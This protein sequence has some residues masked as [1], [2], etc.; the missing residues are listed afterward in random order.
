MH[1]DS[2]HNPLSEAIEASRSGN[3]PALRNWL[4]QGNNP[5]V[6]DD[7]GWTPLL[8]AAARGHHEA[9][10]LLLDNEY[11]KAD[12]AFPHRESAALAIHMAGH[13]GNVRTAEVILDHRPDHLNAVW[14]LN[15]HTVLLQAVFYGHLDMAKVLLQRGADTSITT[16]RGLGPMELCTQFQNQA[17]M[18][19]IRPYDT[20][21]EAKAA[22]YRAYLKR[23][24][25]IVPPAEKDAQSNADQLVA[26]IEEGIRKAMKEP[27]SVGGTLAKIKDLIEN[28]G[29]DVNRLG[30][31]LQQPPLIVTVT[32]NNGWPAIPAA[33]EL[34]LRLAEYLLAHGADPTLHERHPMGAQTIIRAAVFN[35]L[36]ILKLCAKVL[37][38]GKHTDAIN[39]I[40][41]VNGL[42]AL[43]DTVL[44]ATMAGP[45]RFNGYLEQ[46]R[47]FVQNGGRSDI[48]DF[49]GVTQRNIA[50]RA[51]DPEVRKRLLDVLDGKA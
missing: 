48:E 31:P 6:H 27:D 9:V 4:A 47:W 23:I 8:W 39:E 2:Q 5:N 36:E 22:Y 25:P 16:A 50:E 3:I 29:A 26:T 37:T 14:D 28:M 49:A 21:L 35:H 40:P 44:R 20:P 34:R 45:D 46:T 17:M 32:G 51:K 15:G 42:T 11:I 7:S 38:P 10:A 12:P 43:H 33:A 24:A 41:V 13:S 30:G 1:N 18:D 19:L